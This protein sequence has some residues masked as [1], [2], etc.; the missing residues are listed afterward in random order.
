MLFYRCWRC[1]F[2]HIHYVDG[3]HKQKSQLNLIFD[4]IFDFTFFSVEFIGDGGGLL[5]SLV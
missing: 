2:C 3:L 1:C 4:N 5:L